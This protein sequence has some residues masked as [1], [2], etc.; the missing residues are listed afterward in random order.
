MKKTLLLTIF[1][2]FLVPFTSVLAQQN[3]IDSLL[4]VLP[5]LQNDTT[6]VK[7]LVVV[8]IV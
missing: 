4:K 5:T 6:K 1:C 2:L 3:I 7:T 8:Q